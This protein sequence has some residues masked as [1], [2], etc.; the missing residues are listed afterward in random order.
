MNR[1]MAGN[2]SDIGVLIPGPDPLEF[3][4]YADDRTP[5]TYEIG[6]RCL[7]HRIWCLYGYGFALC[8][9]SSL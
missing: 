6:R 9:T 4:A 1:S 2:L 5:V 8:F 7:W 3:C